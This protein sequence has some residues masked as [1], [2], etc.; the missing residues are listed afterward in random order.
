MK[1]M[2]LLDSINNGKKNKVYSKS[3][4][5]LTICIA[6]ALVLLAVTIFIFIFQK[7]SSKTLNEKCKE[8]SKKINRKIDNTVTDFAD[9]VKQ[10]EINTTTDQIRKGE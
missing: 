2:E 5:K 1:L 9:K 8:T 7:K 10:D 4:K 6:S 3:K